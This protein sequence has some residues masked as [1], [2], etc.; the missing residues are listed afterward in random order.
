MAP[1]IY[2]DARSYLLT[3]LE[4]I[5]KQFI[6]L[7]ALSILSYAAFSQSFEGEI[8]YHNTYKSKL[9]NVDDERYSS[10]LGDTLDYFIKDG[11][12][13]SVR[14]GKMLQWQIYIPVE[15]KLYTKMA[16][17]EEA[18]W[19]DATTNPDQVKRAVFK[20]G[21]IKIL[22]Y[23]CDELIL[24]CKSGTQKYYFNSNLGID[25]N[26]FVNHKYGNWYSYVSKSNAVPLKIEIDNIQ[27]TMTCTAIEVKPRKLDNSVFQLPAGL[28]TDKSLY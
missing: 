10:M 17:K 22:G 8:I 18:L 13:K 2:I 23:T 4:F 11:F 12:Y 7:F 25:S 5:M 26:A 20:K 28:S 27:Y 15:N 3:P 1:F 24:H 9:L 19:I 16:N 21:A 6:S 14:N